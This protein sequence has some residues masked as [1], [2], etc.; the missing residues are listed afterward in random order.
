[1]GFKLTTDCV[2]LLLVLII[3]LQND[4]QALVWA[5]Q[6]LKEQ[7]NMLS[8]LLLNLSEMETLGK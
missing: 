1:M 4:R 7:V 3:L 2:L 5:T 6:N 8:F